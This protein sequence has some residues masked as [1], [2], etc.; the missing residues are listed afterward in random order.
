MNDNDEIEYLL[1]EGQALY[2]CMLACGDK[3]AKNAGN[4]CHDM[5]KVIMAWRRGK[6][7]PRWEVPELAKLCKDFETPDCITIDLYHDNQSEAWLTVYADGRI[8]L[9]TENDGY[10]ARH[11]GIDPKDEPINMTRVEE[12]GRRYGK[13]LVGAVTRAL[14]SL[15]KRP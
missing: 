7:L 12:L 6:L 9:H 13:D 4:I 5:V 11:Y 8:N 3:E 14:G 2:L 10:R 1:N 15:G